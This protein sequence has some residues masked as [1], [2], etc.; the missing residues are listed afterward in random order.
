MRLI[1][2]LEDAAPTILHALWKIPVGDHP[3]DDFWRPGNLLAAL[4]ARDGTVERII[5]G[6]GPDQRELQRHPDSGGQLK[7]ARLPEWPALTTLGLQAATAL[8]GL[9]M[10]AWDIALTD[11]GPVLVEVNIGGDFNLPQLAFGRG[12]WT[13]ASRRSSRAARRR[14]A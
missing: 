7:G 5:Q 11:R 13:S 6:V 8:P 9:R 2:L 10:Q 14:R 1:V 3:A 4:D 12:L